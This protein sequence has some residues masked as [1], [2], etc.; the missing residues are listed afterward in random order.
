MASPSVSS[1]GEGARA[2]ERVRA[3][4][5]ALVA[6]RRSGAQRGEGVAWESGDSWT[7]VRREWIAIAAACWVTG[8]GPGNGAA[9]SE[10]VIE[11]LRWA[12]VRAQLESAP[13]ARAP[14]LFWRAAQLARRRCLPQVVDALGPIATAAE[15]SA[16]HESLLE[17]E[18]DAAA[19]RVVHATRERKR[20]GSYLT[21]RALAL[22]TARRALAGGA[23]LPR[24]CDPACGAGVFLSA[25][26]EVLVARHPRRSRAELARRCLFGVDRDPVAVELCRFLL[27]REL[28]DEQ[29]PLAFLDAN[30]RCGD[31]LIG[32][33]Q[34]QARAY[35]AHALRALHAAGARAQPT[36]EVR[37]PAPLARELDARERAD[38]CCAA[39]FWPRE[40]GSLAPKEG[41]WALPRAQTLACATE[42]GEREGFLHWE[43]E[44]PEVFAGPRP[45]FDALLGN[46][47]WEISKPDSRQWFERH[48]AGYRGL[49]K[50]AALARQAELFAANAALARAWRRHLEG[51]AAFARWIREP[52]RAE[53]SRAP[54][55]RRVGCLSFRAQG[56]AD[57]NRYK[58]F[59]ERSFGLCRA[60]GAIAFLVP[61]G[62]YS[63]H[64]TRELR[65]L[66]LEEGHW[67][68][69]FGFDNTAGLFDIHRSYK[70]CA[71][72]VRKREGL[73]R[74]GGAGGANGEGEGEA[75]AA[76]EQ[77]AEPELRA[78]FGRRSA[79][80]WAAAETFVARLEVRRLLG[81][82]PG[83]LA[84]P[85][86]DGRADFE[87]YER[88]H[89]GSVRMADFPDPSAPLRYRREYDMTR[90]SALFLARD[91]LEAR[92][93]RPDRS[94]R[95]LQAA[96][97]ASAPRA[98]TPI[99]SF[100]GDAWT[101]AESIER[102]AL[103]LVQ[104]VMMHQYRGCA[105]GWVRG[106]GARAVWRALDEAR[107][108]PGPQFLVDAELHRARVEGF[109]AGLAGQSKLVFR[110]VARA[111][112]ERSAI[113]T[114]LPDWPCANALAVLHVDARL[115]YALLACLDSFVFDWV[116]RRRL[117][118][119]H[120]NWFVMEDQP[121]PAP[122]RL[123]LLPSLSAC[124]ARLLAAGIGA[125][126][127]HARLVRSASAAAATGAV[128][129]AA[130]G[131]AATAGA[132]PEVAETG[133][134]ALAGA[135]AG[136][137]SDEGSP[138]PSELELRRLRAA[139]E[140][141]VAWLYEL[142]AADFE[143]VL[144]GAPASA[145]RARGPRDA[146][147][148]WRVDKSLP[149]RERLPR[150]ALEAQ[151]ELVG[152]EAREVEAF[153]ARAAASG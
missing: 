146:R 52:A 9:R 138:A 42:I 112:D 71:L 100:A 102:V 84:I 80:D 59:L 136:A 134:A 116:L 27:W 96:W 4:L 93:Y 122:R 151:R 94:G 44:F 33:S 123:A 130:T 36:A 139:V 135:L 67:E 90:D 152:V 48:D 13:C 64:G 34:E 99:R 19:A 24:V 82:S 104:G 105:K 56:R 126:G 21:S 98:G 3:A 22:P 87:L 40:L 129:G 108:I 26:L 88:V 7:A 29:L 91:E 66:F 148:F 37:P 57:T 119:V 62:I 69:L 51:H 131:A 18:F 110:D 109:G 121:L 143:R 55:A 5:D 68:W 49:S 72:I 63:D 45:G 39:W 50:P 149:E 78:A 103:P 89:A 124:V 86:L 14:G 76:S 117:V 2:R 106:A 133:V 35:P 95:W 12:Q 32:C 11:W 140:A 107:A 16:Q 81:H 41:E 85:E 147:G 114:C 132:A 83:S 115:R 77:G 43:L 10:A 101:S 1:R 17:W 153:L 79:A 25:A 97:R 28:G 118:G 137:A 65:R 8:A 92:G 47:P 127:A 145:A 120:L 141:A 150:L 142:S 128:T 15:L 54:G 53:S 30:L 23:S 111:T 46:P 74:A 60:G 58:L 125:R 31:A 61:S 38:L 144:L 73:E 75:E 20:S 70:F 113:A 6:E